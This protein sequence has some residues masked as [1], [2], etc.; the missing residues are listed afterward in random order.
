MDAASTDPTALVNGRIVLPDR[1]VTRLSARHRGRPHRRAGRPGR[2][3]IGRPSASTSAGGWIT[4]GL[5]RHPHPRRAAAHLQRAGSGSLGGHH[6]R[7]PAP[8]DRPRCWP[9]LHRRPIWREG[10]PSAG[11]GCSEDHG[12]ARVLGAYLESPYINVGAEGRAGP[13]VRARADDG[14]AAALLQYAD[15]LRVFMLAPEL[16]GAL[17]PGRA[18]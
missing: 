17:G 1:V 13:L 8:R 9:P 18:R 14:S 12:G 11:S 6:R 10:W 16:P 2:L 5:D 3:R 15:I 4:P 7:E